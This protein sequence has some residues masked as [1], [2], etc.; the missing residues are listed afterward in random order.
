M[1]FPFSASGEFQVKTKEAPQKYL[2]P[3]QASIVHWFE[4]QR[5]RVNLSNYRTLLFRAG[6]FRLVT[7]MNILVPIGT[8]E[9]QVIANNQSIRVKYRFRYTEFLS[10]VT[11]GV[12]S[13]FGLPL[14]KAPNLNELESVGLLLLIWILVFVPNYLISR[15]S[16]PAKL[17][18][19]VQ[20]AILEHD[21]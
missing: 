3:V 11:I 21:T 4:R 15:Y 18:A 16:V 7:N 12:A 9:I 20:Q 2:E 19:A 1:P 5:A 6:V 8:G 10:I 14:W 13:V 17:K